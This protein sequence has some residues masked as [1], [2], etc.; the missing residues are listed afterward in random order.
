MDN[1]NNKLLYWIPRIL[2]IIFILFLA[3]FSLDVFEENYGFWETILG[4]FIHNIPVLIL[5][6]VLIISWQ[7]EWVGG[8]VFI[9]AGVAYLILILTNQPFQW[10][11]LFWILNISGPAFLIGILFLLGWRKFKK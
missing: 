1:K 7:H 11:H 8:L 5:L 10:Y 2:S 3:M 4:L 9:L 6:L